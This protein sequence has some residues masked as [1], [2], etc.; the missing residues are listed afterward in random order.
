[1]SEKEA[2]K[3]VEK[4]VE[5]EE[6][7]RRNSDDQTELYGPNFAQLI[8]P[9]PAIL[10]LFKFQMSRVQGRDENFAIF[11]KFVFAVTSR[12]LRILMEHI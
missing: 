11:E 10:S 7:P 2:E 5:K 1:M 4:E 6:T 12:T 9:E 8:D 3:E